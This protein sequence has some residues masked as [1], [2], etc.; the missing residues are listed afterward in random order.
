[1]LDRTVERF[2]VQPSRLVADAGY[3]LVEIQC[4]LLN[5]RRHAIG[6][7]VITWLCKTERR[8]CTFLNE[9]GRA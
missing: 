3:G 8:F 1:M 5:A 2:D 7:T 4:A 9:P 6:L